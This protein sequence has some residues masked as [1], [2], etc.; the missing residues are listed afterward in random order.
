[1]PEVYDRELCE[2]NGEN[3]RCTCND[4]TQDG[5]KESMNGEIRLVEWCGLG[6]TLR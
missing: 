2:S 3:G 6:G 1:M 4:A 5:F